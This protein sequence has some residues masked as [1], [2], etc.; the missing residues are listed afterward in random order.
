VV[1]PTW[2]N[3]GKMDRLNKGQVQLQQWW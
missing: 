2:S 3:S 1:N